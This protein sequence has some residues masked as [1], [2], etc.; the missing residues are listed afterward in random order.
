MGWLKNSLLFLSALSL[1]MACNPKA[2]DLSGEADSSSTI[3]ATI[4]GVF[5]DAPV[6]GLGYVTNG[7]SSTTDS[8]GSFTCKLGDT[9]TFKV[10]TLTLGSAACGKAVFPMHL[11]GETS[12][13]ATGGAVAMG[14]LLKALDTGAT[15]GVLTIPTA[16]R[17]STLTSSLD[18]STFSSGSNV[19]DLKNVI[20]EINTK[21]GTSINS[22]HIQTNYAT[23]YAPAAVSELTSSLTNSQYVSLASNISSFDGKYFLITGTLQ[24]GQPSCSSL[25]TTLY[26][27][28]GISSQAVGSSTSY[29]AT[30]YSANS[31]GINT[32]SVISKSL[33]TGKSIQ[34]SSITS[35]TP[36]RFVLDFKST[37]IKLNGNLAVVLTSGNSEV[38]CVYTLEGEEVTPST[39]TSPTPPTGGTA[40]LTISDGPVY[41]FGNQTLGSATDKTFTI[42]NTGSGT[43]TSIAASALSS[44]FAFKGGSYPGTGG[45]CTASVAAA[46]SCTVVVTY[47]PVTAALHTDAVSLN[48]NDGSSVQISSR[49]IQGTGQAAG[50][51]I[52]SDAPSYD[53]G[54]QTTGT[55]VDYSFTV[56]NTGGSMATALMG[57]ALSAPFSWKGGTYPGTGGTCAASL[58]GGASC[59]IVVTYAPSSVGMHFETVTLNYNDGSTAQSTTRDV[60]GDGI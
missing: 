35:G 47:S 23:T 21:A 44:P 57:G 2:E 5:V 17:T 24:A 48:Y 51:L 32:A 53:F 27:G 45:T 55:S 40:L 14:V 31:T 6:A 1:L 28:V 49:A 7:T 13:S 3:G 9:V 10:G 33:I 19:G 36:K 34:L 41:S 59:T 38:K 60:L 50:S 54:S 52:I 29:T 15:S 30:H 39:P 43:A 26:E 22:N 37:E 4:T 18:F 12:I 58:A 25:A 46:A 42:T 11:T 8:T 20:D 16:V 56:T